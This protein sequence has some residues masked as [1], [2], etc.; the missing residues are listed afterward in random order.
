MNGPQQQ[1]FYV[2]YD[3]MGVPNLVPFDVNIDINSQGISANTNLG[4]TQPPNAKATSLEELASLHQD[5]LATRQGIATGKNDV[6]INRTMVRKPWLDAPDGS[7][8]F[9]PETAVALPAIGGGTVEVVRHVVPE[10]YDGVIN[11]YSWNYTG[12]N[13]VDG[14]GDIVV[15]MLR[16]GTPIRNYNNI[17]VQKGCIQIPRPIAPLRI[18]SNQV[19]SLVVTH[20]ADSFGVLAGNI[21]GSLV[22][23]D[24]PSR[25]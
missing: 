15:M 9:D 23:Y 13:F 25:G 4:S 10:G 3:D 2:V 5:Y 17:T 12:A 21:I 19:I 24:Y 22:G 20:I 6:D 18:Y 14:S 7:I 1:M 8:S 16:N 11:A